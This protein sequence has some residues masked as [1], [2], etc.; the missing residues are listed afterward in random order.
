MSL[1]VN[2]KGNFPKRIVLESTNH[3]NLR[4][5]SCVTGIRWRKDRG[6]MDFEVFKKVVD[7]ISLHEEC[8]YISLQG[9][10][11]PLLHKR[12]FD[13]FAY[14]DYKN[15]QIR[16]QIS[17]N[18]TLLNEENASRIFDS[19]LKEIVFSVDGFKKE[20]FER[21]RKGAGYDNV[22]SNIMRFLSRNKQMGN[23]LKTFVCF[24]RQTD[25]EKEMEDFHHFWQDKVDDFYYSTYQTFTGI[26]PDK[27]TEADKSKVPSE[28]FACRQLLR[29]D[30]VIH[31]DGTAYPCCRGFSDDLILGNV[32]DSSIASLFN[33]AVRAGLIRNH[34]EK[35]WHDVAGCR[36]CL[37]EWSF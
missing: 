28:R 10:G 34:L 1:V 16:S 35:R 11:E 4:C 18:G 27:R 26:I 15:P 33:G 9:G 19:P 25:N 22:L 23:K 30:F 17:T 6:F 7:E 31:W 32:K 5:P 37:Q 8:F 36:N 13:F 21:L 14:L 24:V 29:G 2:E 12:I 3:C 20:T